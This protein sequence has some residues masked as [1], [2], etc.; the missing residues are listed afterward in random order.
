[1]CELREMMGRVAQAGRLDWIGVRGQRRAHMDTLGMV[2]V[3]DAGLAG[4]HGVAGK[5]AVMLVQAEH[6]GVI[7][8]MLRRGAVDPADLRRNL[9]VSGVN[10]LVFKGEQV[11]IGDVILEVTSPCMPCS[12]ME[13]TFGYGGYG[14]VRGMVDGAPALSEAVL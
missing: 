5:R 3:T 7:G 13:E 1:M 9:V 11:Q 12:R 6:L 2:Q 8:A 14:A 10:L 4:D